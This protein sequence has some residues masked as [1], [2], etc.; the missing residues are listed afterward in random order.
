ME[1][2]IEKRREQIRETT[3]EKY[4]NNKNLTINWND[5]AKITK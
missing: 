1:N 5:L 4:F 2:Q 3:R